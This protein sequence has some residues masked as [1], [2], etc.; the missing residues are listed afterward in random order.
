MIHVAG[1]LTELRIAQSESPVTMPR[2][3]NPALIRAKHT[4]VQ[5]LAVSLVLGCS[6]ESAQPR[7]TDSLELLADTGGP[8]CSG[9]TDSV[10]QDPATPS[11]PASAGTPADAGDSVTSP[12]EPHSVPATPQGSAFA[13]PDVGLSA[14]RVQFV[15]DCQEG[16][17]AGCVAGDD[18]APGTEEAPFRSYARARQAFSEMNAGETIAFCRGG[19]FDIE[20][21]R[22]WVNA[23]CQAG[24]P[25]V[26]RDYSPAG[27]GEDAPKPILR[28]TQDHGF[29][30][31]DGGNSDHE[32]GYVFLNL[33]LRSSS[34][35][36]SG[37]GFF[38]YND[39]DDVLVCGTAMDGFAIGFHVAGSNA[40]APGS[41]GA[42]SRIVLQNA[43]LTNNGDQGYLGGCDG[44]GVEYSSF[45]NN[46]F[47]RVVLNH[48][49]YF[50]ARGAKDMFARHNQLYKS[51]IVDGKCEGASLVVHG[52]IDGL[53]IE[54]N[55]IREDVGAA[56]PGCWGIAV[57][58]GYAGE[59]EAFND[60]VI[61]GN[62][63]TNVGNM[64]IGLNA[65]Q[66]C[67][68]EN[69]VVVQEQPMESTLVSVPD[70]SRPS[71]DQPMD[72]VTVR[73]NTLVAR[74]SS[75][76]V[77]ISL[78]GEGR[79][80]VAVSNALL[81]LGSGNF[82]CFQYDLPDQ[83]YGARDNNLC[84]AASDAS[85]TGDGATL[86]AWSAA[87]TADRASSVADPLFVSSRA[88][89]DWTPAEGSP[90]L[91][92]GHALSAPNDYTGRERGHAPDV[93]AIE[94]H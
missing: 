69:N 67:T 75:N 73:N 33:D 8:L 45:E 23:R 49:I 65:C 44:C 27:V 1:I 77:G 50:G 12:L 42:N 46:G 61:R 36:L 81:S 64:G 34:R 35:G 17:S 79:G 84:H 7:S 87:S 20:G 74:S 19:S 53:L 89:F 26:V 78:G 25:C 41:D 39:I 94:R 11:S 83:E 43:T 24:E 9:G 76:V 92:A 85:W 82:D 40:P 47:N 55:Q 32:E 80:H 56:A 59:A 72:A 38:F 2:M 63:V 15:C 57:D 28:A 6:L 51:A 13:C 10:G 93:G 18:S 70:R 22:R 37:N 31:E 54:G 71:E 91:N 52:R 16:A 14:S 30:F 5:T 88:P 58:T 68:I 29:S 4:C 62:S 60:V 66:G 3:T 90:L 21:D 48:N 86:G